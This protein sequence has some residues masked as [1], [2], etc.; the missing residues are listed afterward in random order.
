M[1]ISFHPKGL[2]ATAV[3]LVAFGAVLS[4]AT[5]VRRGVAVGALAVLACLLVEG[6]A[7]VNP[8]AWW[9]GRRSLRR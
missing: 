8:A 7:V 9:Q 5:D 6:F 2:L 3:F 4:V 1:T